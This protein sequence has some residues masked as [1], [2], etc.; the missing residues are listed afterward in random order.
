MNELRW[1]A[2]AEVGRLRKHWDQI[3]GRLWATDEQIIALL[4][5]HLPPAT[6]VSPAPLRYGPSF[7]CH[8]NSCCIHRVVEI[9]VRRTANSFDDVFNNHTIANGVAVIARVGR[10]AGAPGARSAKNEGRGAL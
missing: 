1:A 4:Q 2:S 10:G 6:F 7:R 9:L 5:A 8:S 3:L